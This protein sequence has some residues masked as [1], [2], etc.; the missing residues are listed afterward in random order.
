MNLLVAGRKNFKIKVAFTLLVIGFLVSLLFTVY[1]P[2][3]YWVREQLNPNSI[4][5]QTLNGLKKDHVTII[6][7][8]EVMKCD[9]IY[10]FGK[11][12]KKNFKEKGRN[13]FQVF[14]DDSLVSVFSHMKT[15]SWE[16]YKYNFIIKKQFSSITAEVDVTQ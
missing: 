8:V 4:D 16:G 9:T 3:Y 14:Y 2:S 11:L 6:L 13:S 10:K 15:Q 12:L 5:V 7:C 1:P